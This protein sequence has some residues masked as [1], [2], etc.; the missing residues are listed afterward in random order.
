[1]KVF[2]TTVL[3]LLFVHDGRSA[4]T[5]VANIHVDSTSIGVGTILFHQRDSNSAVRIVGIIDGLKSNTVHVCFILADRS[6][7]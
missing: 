3:M 5:A 6:I 1:M 4:M 7:T 2:F